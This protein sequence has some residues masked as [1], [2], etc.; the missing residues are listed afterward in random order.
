MLQE[1]VD[2]LVDKK[3]CRSC[4]D[5]PTSFYW[6]RLLEVFPEAKVVLTTRRPETWHKSVKESIYHLCDT[7][8]TFPVSWV[9]H[10]LGKAGKM[11]VCK[12]LM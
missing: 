6:K 11:K 8:N 5:Y 10:L 3:N 7:F 12:K 2:F 1:F 9:R 4:V